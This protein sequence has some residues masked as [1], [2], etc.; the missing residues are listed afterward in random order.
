MTG[1]TRRKWQSHPITLAVPRTADPTMQSQWVETLPF[2][3][4]GA[5]RGP[6]AALVQALSRSGVNIEGI[7]ESDGVVHVLARDPSAARAA[8][9]AGGYPIDGEL[10]VVVMPMPDRPG[11]LSMVMQRLAEAGVT[12]RFVYLATGT[13]VVIGVDDITRARAA[14]EP[15][16]N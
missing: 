8:L 16:Q 11:E 13:R 3:S 7:A 5:R 14:L 2:G 9:R 6:L 10:E 15:A 4:A 1:W 12:L